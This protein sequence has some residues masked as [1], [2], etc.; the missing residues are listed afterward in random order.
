[1]RLQRLRGQ[2]FAF[3]HIDIELVFYVIGSSSISLYEPRS[4]KTNILVSD[5]VPRK[6]GCA[7]TE[8]G[9]RLEISDLESRGIVVSV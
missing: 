1:M 5:Q 9:Y 8:E 2:N 4:E 6:P 7:V 3:V